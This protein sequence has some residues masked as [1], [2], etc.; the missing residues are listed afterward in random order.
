MTHQNVRINNNNNNNKEY[1]KK[2]INK[3]FKQFYL[4]QQYQ[5]IPNLETY[6]SKVGNVKE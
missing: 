1:E 2:N 3:I 4:K 5:K 6:R